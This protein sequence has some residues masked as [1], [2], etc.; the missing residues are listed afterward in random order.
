M[1]RPISRNLLMC[2]L[3]ILSLCGC[4][5]AAF[6]GQA[7]WGHARIML[8]QRPITE[9]LNDPGTPPL[10][11]AKLSYVLEL[12]EFA[13]HELRLPVGESYRDY[14]DIGRSHVVWNVFAAPELSLTPKTWCYPV[15]GCAAYRGYFEQPAAERCAASLSQDGYDVFVWGA[16]AYSTLG[17]FYDPVLSTFLRLDH[18]Q[19]A[20]L[21]FHEL[22]HRRLYIQG[23]SAFN[24]S[25]A[26]AVEQTGLQRWAAVRKEP[27]LQA[28][29]D[30]QRRLQQEFYAWISGS[31]PDLQAVYAS[32]LPAAEKRVRKTAIF[33]QLRRDFECLKMRQPELSRYDRWLASGLNNAGLASVTTYQEMVPAFER[34]LRQS[35]GELSVFYERCRALARLPFGERHTQLRLLMAPSS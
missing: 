2:L 11:R 14:A 10:L 26:S 22:A 3:F 35:N 15:A 9:L 29:V 31:I 32:D 12:R 8:S 16:T 24:E 30:S 23:D 17:W 7:V 1:G 6:Y 25:F 33:F 34:L 4:Q 27:G 13:A 19:L 20:A 28:A 21:M 5:T 18:A